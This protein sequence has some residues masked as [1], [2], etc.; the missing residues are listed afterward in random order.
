MLVIYIA[1]V[2]FVNENTSGGTEKGD[3]GELNPFVY[4]WRALGPQSP[5]SEYS[6]G[7]TYSF[8]G[9]NS[10]YLIVSIICVSVAVYDLC[11]LLLLAWFF[12]IAY[13]QRLIHCYH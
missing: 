12:K 2:I 4:I 5:S 11:L 13:K 3:A 6:V 10:F 7:C 9:R 1:V 8:L